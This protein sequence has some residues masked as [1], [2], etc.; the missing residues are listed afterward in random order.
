MVVMAASKSPPP[1]LL[2]CEERDQSDPKN[3][4]HDFAKNIISFD[5]FIPS[6]VRYHT[7][8]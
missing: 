3:L 7:N 1:S 4:D 8:P 2:W 5:R 6:W